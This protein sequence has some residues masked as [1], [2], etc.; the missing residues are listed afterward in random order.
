MCWVALVVETNKKIT[1]LLNLHYCS[2]PLL[3]TSETS[4]SFHADTLNHNDKGYVAVLKI[5]KIWKAT[6][7]RHNI[8]YSLSL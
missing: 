4:N 1:E 2:L 6:K 3:F 8:E 5:H 7:R